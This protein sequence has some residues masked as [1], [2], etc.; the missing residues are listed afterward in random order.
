[1]IAWTW[2][3]SCHHRLDPGPFSEKI[4]PPIIGRRIQ[5]ICITIVQCWTNVEDVGP[6]LYECYPNVLR[7]LWHALTSIDLRINS[8][9]KGFCQV[10]KIPKIRE[11]L[12]S[13]WVGQAQSRIK[14]FG[15]KC[16]FFVFF[17]CCFHVSKCFKKKKLDRFCLIN[18][19]F[20]QIF[21]FVL[22][23]QDP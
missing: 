10:K 11:K 16:F 9:S 7:L 13:G 15:G 18:P 20:S 5:T 12:G 14:F 6:L 21:G 1:M 8:R 19:S 3:M 2:V 22:T 17:V 4:H 23:W